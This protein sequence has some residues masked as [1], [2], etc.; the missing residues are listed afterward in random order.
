MGAI[1]RAH[2]GRGESH[3]ERN[4]NRKVATEERFSVC[5]TVMG[6][7]SQLAL[8]VYLGLQQQ[9]FLICRL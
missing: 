3:I 2:H 1:L 5:S 8:V 4:A 9:I 6:K 7:C